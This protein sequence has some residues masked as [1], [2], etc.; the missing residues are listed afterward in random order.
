MLLCSSIIFYGFWRFDFIPVLFMSVVVDY[1]AALGIDKSQTKLK[2]NIFLTCSIIAN[3]G[4]LIYFKYTIFILENINIL[5]LGLGGES[6]S[7]PRDIILPLGLSFYTFQS[8]SYTIDVYR[9]FIKP[10]R[11]FILFADYV[12]FFPQLV[13]GPILRAREVLTQL[14]HRVP[15]SWDNI[16]YGVRRILIGLFLKV[17]LADHV[18]KMVDYT[19]SV[20][21]ASL[22]AFD[23]W[24]MSFLFG[25][26]IYFD[27]SA[28]SH[29]A[30]GSA[31]LM[32][33]EF[34]ENF[35][36]PYSATSPRDFWKRW[37]ISLSSWIRDYLYLPLCHQT[38]RDSSLGGIGSATNLGNKSSGRSTVALFAT[39]I[40]MGLW[41]GSNW[42]FALWGLWHATLVFL[43]RIFSRLKLSSLLG[44][45]FSW[46]CTIP[47]VM[48]GWIAFRAPT[49]ADC[50]MLWK[51]TIMP[52]AYF[53]PNA[54]SKSSGKLLGFLQLSFDL[55]YY[56]TAMSLTLATLFAGYVAKNIL[57]FFAKKMY[58]IFF[59]G[60]TISYSIIFALG[61]V[62]LEDS[63][64][65]VYFQF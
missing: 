63:N 38:V 15:F 14:R 52:S 47:L 2:K 5:S 8:M 56:L 60:E 58:S 41:H 33:I 35:N 25:L 43:G 23:T 24:T 20:P 27:F 16:A 9:G 50:L 31:R 12:L 59:L 46:L 7:I 28:Y 29:I 62:Y 34:P 19:F 13:A 4:L 49:L 36:F 57:P 51:R 53:D 64:V 21:A 11:N 6:V 39:W 37:H 48:L 55:D 26:Q 3:L 40:I 22:N 44:G 1:F 42:T 17:Y 30:I 32:G 61:Y 18:G 54:L 65:F 45:I 10:E